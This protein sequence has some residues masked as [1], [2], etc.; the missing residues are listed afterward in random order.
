[1]N[2]QNLTIPITGMSCTNCSANI[3]RTVGKLDGVTEAT[4]NFAAEQAM[5]SFDSDKIRTTDIVHKIH[6]LGFK[7]PVSTKELPITGMS[8]V[9]CAANIERT[10]NKKVRG[11]VSASV[12]FASEQLLVDYIPSIV[13]LDTIVSE[14][15]KIGFDLIVAD[16]DQNEEDVEEIA[17]H[18]Q[19][20]DQ[21]RKFIVGAAFALPLFIM[22]MSRD[23]GLIGSWSHASWM[24]WFFLFLA[25][26]VQFYTGM[27]Y[28]VGAYKAL[29]NKSA[30]M[31]VLIA[32]GSSVAYFYSLCILVLPWLGGHVYFE[33]SAVIITL[34]KFG[35]L[36]EARTKGKTGGAIKKL[37]KLQ[38]KTATII[39]NGREQQI[40]I[41]M[42]QVN[43]IIVIRPGEKICVDGVIIEGISA[44]DESMLSGEPIP[45]DKTTGDDVTGGTVNVQ[46]LLKFK[47]T[48]VGKDTAL[49]R[50]IQM[51]REAQGSKA[52]IQALADKVAAVFVPAVISIALITFGIWWG[53]TGEFVP[54]M[55]RM[56]AVLVIACPCA[57]GLATP[58]AIMAGTGKGAENGIL[59]K[60]SEALENAAKLDT[61][62]LD[63]TGTV[64]M[65]KPTVVDW[66]PAKTS[67]LSG[68]DLLSLAASLEKG[69]EH[70]I[71]K[72]IVAFA[73]KKGLVLT[74][75][76]Q[77]KA[78]SGFGVEARL[79]D[80]VFRL[81][82]PGWFEHEQGLPKEITKDINVLQNK[83]RTVM[84]LAKG[85][86]ALGIVS[87]SDVLKPESEQ[88]VKQLHAEH[89]N[90][91]M[92][93]GDNVQTARAIARQVGVD[94]V[95]AEVRPEEKSKKIKE[96]QQNNGR[97]GMVGD[98]INDAPALAI[99]DIGF[100]I[101][102]G[103]DVAIETGDV[104]LSGGKLTGIPT[105]IKISRKTMATIKQNLFLA[106]VYNIV[107][108]P[109]AAGILAPFEMFP[110]FL[111]Q[112]HPILAALAMAASSIS[113]VTNSLRLY[114]ADIG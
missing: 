97:V 43:D 54:S 5:I 80:Q 36:L 62:V 107:L 101:G 94:E 78:H 6:D 41:S 90:V 86:K 96:L 61:I 1:M 12:N 100:A 7:V 42:V 20:L 104:I 51:V 113:V 71:G 16:E 24:N 98:G 77:F 11:V 72:A 87:V 88:A 65:G 28:Y 35:K 30:N 111:R 34:I 22:S 84:M 49:S 92:L 82:K 76:V 37:I 109:V 68:N 74:D 25:T 26:P 60:K 47:A 9:N 8:C 27:D 14:I 106:F 18:A 81:G 39:A 44:V 21:T 70:P 50:I 32:L 66:I 59:F 85:K 73:Q 95:Y 63:K 19:I 79:N 17:R 55:I 105:A 102:T 56:V 103:T 3:E 29:K 83:G 23:F 67:G 46:G 114:T 13:S 112:L 53:V 108:I 57:L 52:P 40:P 93:T 31:D 33:T 48:R 45:V 38:P 75:P 69:S 64:T 15:K 4:V 110:D 89:L 58:T 10:L 2:K 99:A 91:V